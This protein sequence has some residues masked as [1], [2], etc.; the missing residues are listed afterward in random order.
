MRGEEKGK[1]PKRD[2]KKKK[3][4]DNP[5][6]KKKPGK[7]WKLVFA[8]RMLDSRT[9]LTVQAGGCTRVMGNKGELK[10]VCE[11]VS[12]RECVCV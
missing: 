12:V 5:P 9:D 1:G 3:Q 7:Q 11:C 4:T 2:F 8:F 6:P 10:C